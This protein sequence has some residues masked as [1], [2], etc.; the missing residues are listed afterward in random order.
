MQPSEKQAHTRNWGTVQ[1]STGFY[2]T[3]MVRSV[4][5]F[6]DTEERVQAIQRVIELLESGFADAQ[7]WRQII[8]DL[9]DLLQVH[10]DAHKRSGT[11]YDG[12]PSIL[13][14]AVAKEAACHALY[15]RYPSLY[16]GGE[17]EGAAYK[18]FKYLLRALMQNPETAADGLK[19][20]ERSVN[21]MQSR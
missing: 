17:A 19:W 13:A 10:P 7:K 18:V 12:A 16:Q 6:A 4:V 2:M 15:K 9:C 3:D 1:L 11:W 8:F 20:V 5:Q 21:L 14:L